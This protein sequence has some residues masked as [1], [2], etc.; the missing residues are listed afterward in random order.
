LP[1][2]ILPDD[3][4]KILSVKLHSMANPRS[5]RLLR[6]LCERVNETEYVFPGTELRLYFE[7]PAVASEDAGGQEF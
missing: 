2:D 1:A 3:E 5:N 4:R 7:A 6:T